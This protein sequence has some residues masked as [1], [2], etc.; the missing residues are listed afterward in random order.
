MLANN[1][2]FCFMSDTKIFCA[3]YVVHKMKKHHVLHINHDAS[4]RNLYC[5]F[6]VIFSGICAYELF[7]CKQ[8]KT[9]SILKGKKPA[10]IYVLYTAYSHLALYMSTKY[11]FS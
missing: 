10:S 1:N 5:I 9:H 3:W 4:D 7:Y 8:T 6:S 2:F 11:R